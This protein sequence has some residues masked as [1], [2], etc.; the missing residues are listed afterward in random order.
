MENLGKVVHLHIDTKNATA[1]MY[2]AVTHPKICVEGHLLSTYFADTQPLN[3]LDVG[4]HIVYSRE[5]YYDDLQDEAL[6]LVSERLYSTRSRTHSWD[7]NG[8]YPSFSSTGWDAIRV[9]CAQYRPK[10]WMLLKHWT[11]YVVPQYLVRDIQNSLEP[12]WIFTQTSRDRAVIVAGTPISLQPIRNDDKCS[13]CSVEAAILAYY[14]LEKYSTLVQGHLTITDYGFRGEM[15][16]WVARGHGRIYDHVWDIQVDRNVESPRETKT[17]YRN[18]IAYKLIQIEQDETVEIRSQGHETLRLSN[19]TLCPKQFL[20][21]HDIPSNQEETEQDYVEPIKERSNRESQEGLLSVW[22][23][24]QS[25]IDALYEQATDLLILSRKVRSEMK[26]SNITQESEVIASD[27]NFE[28]VLEDYIYKI[29]N[30]Q[31]QIK[32]VIRRI[33]DRKKN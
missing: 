31:T 24:H 15:P 23:K 29:R 14:S 30:R 6:L 5:F 21:Q 11:V 16:V 10:I 17:L 9:S 2:E 7:V 8:A 26:R 13:L 4:S 28:A 22:S 12:S 25:Q 27:N 18:G 1:E 33:R 32:Q 3:K 20:L 19:T